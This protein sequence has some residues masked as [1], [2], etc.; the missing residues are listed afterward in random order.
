MIIPV[1]NEVFGENYTG[2]EEIVFAPNEHFLNR[3]D[4]QEQERITDTGF[5]STQIALDKGEIQGNTISYWQIQYPNQTEYYAWL[6]K[7]LSK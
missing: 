1:I 5:M 4:G 7:T 6:T 3:E 2:D